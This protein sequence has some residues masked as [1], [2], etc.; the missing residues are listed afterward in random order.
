MQTAEAKVWDKEKVL[1]LL[2]SS[3]LATGRALWS[4]YERQTADEQASNTTR[5]HNGV[6]FNGRDAEFL[7]GIA[8]R[9]PNYGFTLTPKQLPHVRRA[10][11]KYTRQLL[12]VIEEKGGKVNYKPPKSEAV[13]TPAAVIE[14]QVSVE[15]RSEQ[16][17]MF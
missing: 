7:S 12:E 1:A 5:E 6:G 15:G 10:L 13:E 8:K 9:L 17:G 11:S 14:D 16:F 2:A 3:N 4:L